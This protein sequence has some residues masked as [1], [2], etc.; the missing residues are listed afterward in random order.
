MTKTIRIGNT[1]Y[2]AVST[3]NRG[4]RGK[5]RYSPKRD[6][7]LFFKSPAQK[8][9]ESRKNL[10]TIRNKR[11]IGLHSEEYR[12]EKVER[13]RLA[14]IRSQQAREKFKQRAKNL[15]NKNVS[16]PSIFKRKKKEVHPYGGFESARTE[17]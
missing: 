7:S 1:D 10:E 4:N 6:N 5:R 9:Y 3:S 17:Q 13:K 11:Q 16:V 12:K 2:V 14:K 8:A 15:Y